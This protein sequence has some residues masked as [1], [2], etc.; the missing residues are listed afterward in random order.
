MIKEIEELYDVIIKDVSNTR[1]Y[2][3]DTSN[4]KNPDLILRVKQ[5]RNFKLRNLI[6]PHYFTISINEYEDLVKSIKSSINGSK[7]DSELNIK[8]VMTN[9]SIDKNYERICVNCGD[10]IEP[11]E[12]TVC[13]FSAK[14]QID[15]DYIEIHKSCCKEFCDILEEYCENPK[16][17][18]ISDELV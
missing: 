7:S 15:P 18:L 5:R 11:R 3:T 9:G 6:N 4:N 2:S 17:V 10:K 14:D 1:H 13:H 16:S 12:D 8:C